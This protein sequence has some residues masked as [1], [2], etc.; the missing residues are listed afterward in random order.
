MIEKHK[1]YNNYVKRDENICA[2]CRKDIPELDEN[3][4]YKTRIDK[5]LP[6]EKSHFK[7][8]HVT[9]MFCSKECK[10]EFEKERDG[11]LPEFELIEEDHT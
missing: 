3:L 6:G 11:D 1:Y 5:K 10:E 9:Y 8:L 2:I 4:T 7:H